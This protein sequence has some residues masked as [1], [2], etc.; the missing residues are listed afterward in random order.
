MWVRL[1]P[2]A[3]L[4]VGAGSAAFVH[5]AV[6]HG[7]RRIRRVELVA[8]GTAHPAMAQHMPSPALAAQSALPDAARAI[9]WGIVPLPGM[10]RGVAPPISLAAE[11]DD[12]RRV[13]VELPVQ[14]TRDRDAA[15]VQA[16]AG[17]ETVAI[18][19]AT[20]EPEP[21]LLVRQI[22]SLLEQTHRE[23][24]CL[25]SDDCSSPTA[26][27][28][29]RRLVGTDPRFVISRADR[30]AG[31]YENFGRALAMVPRTAGYVA[32]CDQD[33]RWYPA[34]LETL[35]GA[36]GQAR[37][38]FSD[39]RLTRPDGSVLAGTYWTTRRPNHRNFASLLLGNSVT[40]AASLFERT[41]LDDALPLPPPVGN[42]YHDHWL[43]LVAAATGEIAYVPRPL[44]DYVQHPAAV[45][46]HAGANRGVVGGSLVR[47]LAAL[48]GRPPGRLRTEWRRIYF[49]E[50]CRMAL[51]AY[52]LETRFGGRIPAGTRRALGLAT[53][54]DSAR[55]PIAWLALRQA[56]RLVHDDTGGSETGMLRGLAWRR[57]V[58]RRDPRDPLNDADLPAA[59]RL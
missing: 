53:A 44:Y 43:A 18:C 58:A 12:G 51:T 15:P 6:L 7:E 30:R 11:L 50:Y 31:A 13:E 54:A 2:P 55:L 59:S 39:M 56:R 32:L 33:D 3:N 1:A 27:A 8:S 52:A 25:I 45:I 20:Y 38:V 9:F 40:G 22:R 14:G 17:P 21:D 24:V 41:L 42:L 16:E 57:L 48:R 26:F 28:H 49:G 37:L 23:W 34:K 19:M 29:I 36:L 4:D 35:I 47:R 46:G 10:Q 5:G